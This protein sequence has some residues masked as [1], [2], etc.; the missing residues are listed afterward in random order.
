MQVSLICALARNRTIGINN[1]LPWHLSED[2]K[3]FKR[4]TMGCP[5]IMGRKTWE[6][7]GRPLPGRTNIVVSRDPAY[8]AEGLKAVT[9]IDAALKIAEGVCFI[10]GAEQCFVIGGAALY[11]AALPMADYLHL[12]R[13]HAEITGDTWF[14][15]FDEGD[16]DE[17]AREDYQDE[18]SELD[19]S[20]CL[21]KRR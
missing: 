13:V 6:S 19:Y 10:E 11:A 17:V 8:Q 18:K 9:S 3:Y 21:L 16:W 12:T 4:V 7:I 20:I 15:E 2:L 1:S 14:P 5:I